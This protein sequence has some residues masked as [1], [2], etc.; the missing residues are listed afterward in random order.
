MCGA[1]PVYAL[2]WVLASLLAMR[3]KRLHY[4]QFACEAL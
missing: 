2:R 3:R 4:L 1:N